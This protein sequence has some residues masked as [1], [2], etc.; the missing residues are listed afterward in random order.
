MRLADVISDEKGVK[1]VRQ[2]MALPTE[3]SPQ[4]CTFPPK[5]GSF[6]QKP[7]KLLPKPPAKDHHAHA[8][9][10]VN[11]VDLQTHVVAESVYANDAPAKPVKP[12]AVLKPAAQHEPS[13]AA[14][15]TAAATQ[16]QATVAAKTTAATN[17]QKTTKQ[18]VVKQ[19]S[20]ELMVKK[21]SGE[22]SDAASSQDISPN[23]PKSPA[24]NSFDAAKA[25]TATSQPHS[26]TTHQNDRDVDGR[27]QHHA[28]FVGEMDRDTCI[29]YM[30]GATEGQFVIRQSKVASRLTSFSVLY[31]HTCT[32]T[33][34][35]RPTFLHLASQ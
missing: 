1:T 18:R 23:K 35:C 31:L 7:A 28:W 4:D 21:F 17:E 10:H 3:T 14:T 11:D 25:G 6:K 32:C 27:Q 34:T 29:E 20:V 2:G 24:E 33:Y 22:N 12:P 26:V 13:R 19:S 15:S 16:P 8:N 9:S 5:D 30:S